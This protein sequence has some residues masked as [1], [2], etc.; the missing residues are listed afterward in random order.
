MGVTEAGVTPR[1]PVTHDASKGGVAPAS[2]EF[3]R[4]L[5]NLLLTVYL[6]LFRKVR[7]TAKVKRQKFD[8]AAPG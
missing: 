5:P 6:L 7:F 8:G 2:S 3:G 1:F 4:V